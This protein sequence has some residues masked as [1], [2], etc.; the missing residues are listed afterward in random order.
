MVQKFYGPVQNHLKCF[1][2]PHSNAENTSHM[3]LSMKAE[4]Q[5]YITITNVEN[6]HTYLHI[7]NATSKNTNTV[8]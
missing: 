2:E 1:I 3:L 4:S 6:R 5:I 7:W 8:G